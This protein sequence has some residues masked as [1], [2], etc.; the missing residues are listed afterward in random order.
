MAVVIRKPEDIWTITVAGTAPELHRIPS[1]QTQFVSASPNHV[2]RYKEK[3][4]L[5]INRETFFLTAS[6]WTVLVGHYIQDHTVSLIHAL[7]PHTG[8]VV[9]ALV[10]IVLNDSLGAGDHIVLNGQD[11]AQHCG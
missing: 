11:S 4:N 3:L 5:L 7:G 8:Q 10:D 2:Q 9:Y 6:I 1:L